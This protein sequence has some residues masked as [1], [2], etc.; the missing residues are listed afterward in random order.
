[1]KRRTFSEA[2]LIAFTKHE[3]HA[4]T[5]GG[6]YCCDLAAVAKHALACRKALR[7]LADMNI[8]FEA[9]DDGDGNMRVRRFIDVAHI[10]R[11]RKL[12]APAREGK[13]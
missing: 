12:L 11:A 13:R 6:C 1:M 10:E 5:I 8:S 2:V 3:R 9:F 4:Q 7:P